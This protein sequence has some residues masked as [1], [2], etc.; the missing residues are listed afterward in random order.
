MA[1]PR[2]YNA[3]VV[4]RDGVMLAT[5][6]YLPASATADDGAPGR[7]TARPSPYNK[8]SAAC[9]ALADRWNQRGY[10]LVVGDVRGRGDSDGEFVPYVNEGAD[11]NNT[12][13]WI[14]NK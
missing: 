10:A 6:V 9:P 13:G 2:I 1:G 14:P 12:I 5:D 8:N 3:P 4:T 7:S 11:G